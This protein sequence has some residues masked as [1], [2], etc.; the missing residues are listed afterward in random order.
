MRST[1][2]QVKLKPLHIFLFGCSKFDLTSM[3]R[4]E[5]HLPQ[6]DN[7][8]LSVESGVLRGSRIPGAMR[9]LPNRQIH[10]SKSTCDSID[11]GDADATSGKARFEFETLK[12]AVQWSAK[13]CGNG[14]N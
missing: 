7:I 9:A 3:R 13:S 2:Q 6:H 5:G 4:E 8:L 10:T 12:L 14:E 1:F 11:V